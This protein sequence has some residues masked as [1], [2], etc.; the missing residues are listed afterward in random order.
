MNARTG[1][2]FDWVRH[3][4]LV[5]SLFTGPS[6]DHT[7][8][9]TNGYYIYM[10]ATGR[11]NGQKTVLQSMV[12]PPAPNGRCLSFWYHMYTVFPFGTQSTLAVYLKNV[13]SKFG[14][15]LWI[16]N[17]SAGNVWKNA[18]VAFSSNTQY[19]ILLVA[20][21]GQSSLSDIAIDDIT[22]STSCNTSLTQP[23]PS[24]TRQAPVTLPP[25]SY[26][27][28]FERGFCGWIQGVATD[29]LNWT[30]HQGPTSS[31]DTGPTV[32]HTTGS[33]SGWYAYVEGSQFS[34]NNSAQL[35]SQPISPSNGP[36]CLQFWY[37]MFGEDINTFNVY[38]TFTTGNTKPILLFTRTGNQGPGWKYGRVQVTQS[39][40]FQ[41]IFETHHIRGGFRSDIAIDD[42]KF[43]FQ[44]CPDVALC[45]FESSDKCSFTQD[46]NDNFD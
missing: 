3:K 4:G 12:F 17:T 33:A 44:P 2:N 8:G 30:R 32:D 28:N 22:F 35:Y 21:R 10:E 42:I 25:T 36:M 43:N 16:R 7:L 45:D 6:V 31:F 9:T 5:P 11:S 46:I 24:P 34:S 27:C 29:T 23:T 14:S 20:I 18:H 15:I 13:N 41:F 26:D 19:Q 1:D 40:T 38:L 37:N 39:N